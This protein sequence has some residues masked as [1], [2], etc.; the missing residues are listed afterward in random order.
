[1]VLGDSGRTRPLAAYLE[2]VNVERGTAVRERV[3]H[4]RQGR[5]VAADAAAIGLPARTPQMRSGAMARSAPSPELLRRLERL[6]QPVFLVGADARSLDWLRRH[7]ARLAEHGAVGFL[8]EAS[9]EAD[10]K[11][12][13]RAGDGLAIVPASASM[14]AE[15]L[16]LTRYPVLL[17][18]GGI[19]Q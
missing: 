19:E 3:H 4:T 16:G 5:G 6:P 18:A 1:V 9:A 14:L 7:R 15:V 2:V 12:V 11:A 17:S 13:R 8:V 10:L